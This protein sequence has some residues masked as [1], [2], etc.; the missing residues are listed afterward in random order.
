MSPIYPPLYEHWLRPRLHVVRAEKLA[1]CDDCAMVNPV[2]VTRD[3][4]PFRADL[5]C[6]T[7]FPYVPNFGLG[8]ML[9]T[10]AAGARVRFAA[11]KAQGLFLPTGLHAAAERE[12]LQSEAGYDAFGK[13]ERLL[14]P[15]HDRQRSRCGVW[16]NR[17]GVCATYFCKTEAGFPYWQDVEAYLNHFEWG[18]ANWTTERM[19][20]DEERIEMCKAALSIEESGEERDYFLRAAWGADFGQEESFFRRAL[21]TARGISDEELAALI[22]DRGTELELR[23]RNV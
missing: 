5:K 3:P 12:V 18:L 13:D 15:F 10:D 16:L 9:Q 6:C 17:P 4:G 14:C 11:A 1:T 2:G 19:G 22:G 20:V 21:E 23:I 7:Y 8:A